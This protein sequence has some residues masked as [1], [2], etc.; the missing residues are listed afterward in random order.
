P[1]DEPRRVDRLE[2]G[3]DL[4]DDPRDL[5][6]A[7]RAALEPLRERLAGQIL[8]GVEERVAVAPRSE[9]ARHARRIERAE[10]LV[11]APEAREGLGVGAVRARREHLEGDELAVAR[12]RREVDGAH[13]AAAE[14]AADPVP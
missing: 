1:V 4:V 10:R 2:R 13:G 7:E 8:H 14:D 3:A 12:P 5:G 9:E 11:L 6:L